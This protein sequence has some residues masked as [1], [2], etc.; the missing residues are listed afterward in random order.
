MFYGLT[1]VFRKSVYQIRVVVTT[2]VTLLRDIELGQK[3]KLSFSSFAISV[4]HHWK[5]P[6][7]SGL[8]PSSFLYYS[9]GPLFCFSCSCCL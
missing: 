2:Y 3:C 5:I 6:Y 8:Q 7:Y 1:K 4:S 9:T